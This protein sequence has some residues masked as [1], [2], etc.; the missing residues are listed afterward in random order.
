MMNDTKLYL[1]NEKHNEYSEVNFKANKNSFLSREKGP[2][3]A[4]GFSSSQKKP[5]ELALNHKV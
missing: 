5:N 2:A 1:F 4:N 3:R